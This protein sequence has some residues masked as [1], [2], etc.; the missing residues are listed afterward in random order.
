M[1]GC[2]MV[3]ASVRHPVLLID[4]LIAEGDCLIAEGGWLLDGGCRRAPSCGASPTRATP[5]SCSRCARRPC[6]HMAHAGTGGSHGGHM[7]MDIDMDMGMGSMGSQSSTGGHI[8]CAADQPATSQGNL[9]TTHP[10]SRIA[11]GA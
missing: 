7:G 8:S 3:A 11:T 5:R 1:G 4:W 2:L 9:A 6:G 10:R